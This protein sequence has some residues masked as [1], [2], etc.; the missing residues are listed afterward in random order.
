MACIMY[1]KQLHSFDSVITSDTQNQFFLAGTVYV[2]AVFLEK[3][4][5]FTNYFVIPAYKTT[6]FDKRDIIVD[7][8]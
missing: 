1:F 7:K 3:L 5:S 8:I 4:I 2:H 6:Q